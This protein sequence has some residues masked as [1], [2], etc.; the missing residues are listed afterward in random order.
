MPKYIIG[1]S[2][3]GEKAIEAA[4]ADEA[5]AIF[6]AISARDLAEDGEVISFEPETPEERAAR[7]EKMATKIAAG[8]PV[9]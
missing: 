7:R 9:Q 3:D 5:Q 1:Y 2:I 4:S 8:A 6:D